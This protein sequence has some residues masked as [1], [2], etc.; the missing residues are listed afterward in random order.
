[1]VVGH[2]ATD[3]VGISGVEGGEQGVQLGPEG[4]GDG[5]ESL[6]PGILALLLLLG[7]LLRLTWVHSWCNR[8]NRN[9]LPG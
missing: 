8:T 2:D 6:R 3:E 5:L 1:M 4:R 7:D 9:C